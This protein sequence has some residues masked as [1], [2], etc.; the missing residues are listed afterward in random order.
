M[1]STDITLANS[2]VD[3]DT[4]LDVASEIGFQLSINGAETFRIEESVYRILKAYGFD[5]Q[6]YAI[7]T[8]MHISIRTDSGKIISRMCRIGDHGTDMDGIE[9]YSGLSRKICEKKPD[10]KEAKRW[11]VEAMHSH[12]YYKKIMIYFAHF[13][14]GGGFSLFFG[15]S[16]L[17]SLC[18]GI[19]ALLSG[20]AERGLSNYRVNRFFR[21]AVAGFIMAYPAYV[22][23]GLGIIQNPDMAIVGAIMPLI[24]GLLFTNAMRDIFY[25][26]T[27]SAMNRMLQVL[28]LA[29]A[30]ALGASVAFYF[31][32]NAWDM[33][34]GY[35]ICQYSCFIHGISCF[36]ACIGFSILFNVHGTDVHVCAAG[37]LMVWVVYAAVYYLGYSELVSCFWASVFSGCFSECMAR[38]RKNPAYAYLAVSLVPLIPGSGLYNTMR[39][40][41]RGDAQS[42]VTSCTNTILLAAVMC[43]GIIAVNSI[44][45]LW[46]EV[47][48]RAGIVR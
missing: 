3:E 27:I 11:M 26:D 32:L 38:V 34:E 20:I 37:G 14:A 1:I 23:A 28:L 17:D 35:P 4:L 19:C 39:N 41:V 21:T 7:P 16:F 44:F 6:V 9:L 45:R 13:L 24:P 2:S 48:S 42:F 43:I 36:I 25:G 12:E 46:G 29:T 15:G 22:M 47:K 18:G 8:Y 30:I 5:A 31:A 33:S 10:M 40:A